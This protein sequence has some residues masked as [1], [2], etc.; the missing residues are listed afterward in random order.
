MS[1]MQ[2]ANIG[3][4]T[5]ESASRPAH[6]DSCSLAS[7]VTFSQDGFAQ[8]SIARRTLFNLR[9]GQR[10]I[11]SARQRRLNCTASAGD[12]QLRM[13]RAHDCESQA[14]CFRR[15]YLGQVQHGLSRIPG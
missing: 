1:F 6:A 15:L 3:N 7:L 14:T 12:V 2:C 8:A 11:P 4:R 9:A 10:A 13:M 5:A